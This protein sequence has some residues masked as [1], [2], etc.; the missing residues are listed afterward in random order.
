MNRKIQRNNENFGNEKLNTFQK[1]T[2]TTILLDKSLKTTSEYIDFIS[3]L[4]QID[5]DNQMQKKI[6]N[7]FNI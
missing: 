7:Y 2:I 1:E 3:N 5:L 6:G 4:N